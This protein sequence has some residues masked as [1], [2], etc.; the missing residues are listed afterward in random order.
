[1]LTI[2]LVVLSAALVLVTIHI[3]TMA[4]VAWLL[5]AKPSE[6]SIWVGPRLIQRQVKGVQLSLGVVPMGG[7]VKFGEIE[8]SLLDR[9]PLWRQI[10][11][12]ASGCA[13]LFMIGLALGAPFSSFGNTF[14]QYPLG[15]LQ[16]FDVGAAL[17]RE[18][19]ALAQSA[20]SVALGVASMK[21]SAMNLFPLRM[22]NGGDIIHRVV[23]SLGRRSARSDQ[24]DWYMLISLGLLLLLVGGWLVALVSA[25][26]G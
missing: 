21:L 12:A 22:L 15:A 25:Y 6:V 20:P 23:R 18:W 26:R 5:G 11:T 3:I 24:A 17:L 8:S 2:G 4:G 19:A 9:Q 7:Y 10:A 14:W 13:V 16:P 1:M